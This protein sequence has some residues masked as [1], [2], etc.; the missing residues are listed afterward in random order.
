MSQSISVKLTADV[1]VDG[2]GPVI[3]IGPNG[4][5]KARLGVKMVALNQADMVPALRDIALPP[6]ITLRSLT[7]ATQELRNIVQRQRTSPWLMSNEIHW[8][9]GKLMIEDFNSA[10][11]F[12]DRFSAGEAP[13]IETTK[14]MRLR[15]SWSRLFP[16]RHITFEGHKP[17]VVS[18]YASTASGYAA[19]QMSD[20]ERV[21]LYLAGR[22]LDNLLVGLDNR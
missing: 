7:A 2:C 21:A 8:L 17:T 15:L 13:T 4:S 12:R 1:A 18:D 9:F 5:G 14:L 11:R 3:L 16:G 20:G 10:V 22:V 19:Q 6:D